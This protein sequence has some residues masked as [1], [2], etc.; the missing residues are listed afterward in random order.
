[1]TENVVNPDTSNK[2][3][4]NKIKNTIKIVAASYVITQLDG[5]QGSKG[6]DNK[7]SVLH[8]DYNE[9]EEAL[10]RYELVKNKNLTPKYVLV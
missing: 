7:V 9:L 6:S 5:I 8:E 4:C 3:E 1:M 10:K 2:S